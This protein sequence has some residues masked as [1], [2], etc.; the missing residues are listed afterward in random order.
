MSAQI[1]T[2]PSHSTSKSRSYQSSSR[3]DR[4]GSSSSHGSSIMGGLHPSRA[5]GRPAARPP[6]RV[7]SA[8]PASR[9]REWQTRDAGDVL[10][11]LNRESEAG[12]SAEDTGPVLQ[13]AQL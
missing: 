7:R 9:S 1:R 6:N 5:A 10:Y 2:E 13:A 4:D 8:K 3:R 11:N 12:A